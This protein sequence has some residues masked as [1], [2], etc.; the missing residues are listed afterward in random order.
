M[1]HLTSIGFA[2]LT[3]SVHIDWSGLKDLAQ[4]VAP[5]IAVAGI[6][7]AIRIARQTTSV[8]G[9][10]Q[11]EDRWNA[12][13]FRQNWGKALQHI[14]TEGDLKSWDLYEVLT[15]FEMLGLL[16]RTRAVAPAVACGFFGVYARYVWRGCQK[17]ISD[18]RSTPAHRSE[19]TDFEYLVSWDTTFR[20]R[21]SMSRG[22]P[23]RW[24]LGL[25]I[26]FRLPYSDRTMHTK[27]AVQI[28][29]TELSE[30]LEFSAPPAEQPNAQAAEAPPPPQP[31]A[32]AAAAPLLKRPNV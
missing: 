3:G 31:N 23:R 9:L 15:F 29:Y 11:M 14:K 5:L 6:V 20:E 26:W 10:L 16:V 4:I 25:R 7:Y 32:Q 13:T 2:T 1:L 8:T 28:P 27:L 17:R 30:F 21:D 24:W 22:N 19:W 12:R 18:W